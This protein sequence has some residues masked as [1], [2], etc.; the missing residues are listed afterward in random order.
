EQY[1]SLQDPGVFQ[2]GGHEVHICITGA[3][4]MS[5][6]YTLTKQLAA[7]RYD[8]AIQAGVAGSFDRDIDLGQV[9]LVQSETP[10]DIGAEDHDTFL[11]LVALGLEDPS[12]FPFSEGRL[13]CPL[14]DIPFPY[15][16][17]TVS[18]LTVNTT[19]GSARTIQARNERF[20]CQ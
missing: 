18:G 8:L 4:M 12:D 11:G 10:G 2:Y 6:T 7:H 15:R 13:E 1:G 9:V 19:S 3:G 20:N 17:L 16:L 14:R 5:A